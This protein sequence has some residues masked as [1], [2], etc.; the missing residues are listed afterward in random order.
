MAET[1][2]STCRKVK[3]SVDELFEYKQS[4][5]CLELGCEF[6]RLNT[7]KRNNIEQKTLDVLFVDISNPRTFDTLC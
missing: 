2:Y 5:Q 3:R 1:K 7:E 6:D 4:Q